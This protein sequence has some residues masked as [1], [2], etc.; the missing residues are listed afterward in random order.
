[1][2]PFE[3]LKGNGRPFFRRRSRTNLVQ[4]SVLLCVVD[5]AVEPVG[6]EEAGGVVVHG[7]VAHGAAEARRV[8][9]LGRHLEDVAVGDGVAAQRALRARGPGRDHLRLKG[10][11]RESNRIE[12]R[13]RAESTKTEIENQFAAAQ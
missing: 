12:F 7:R 5:L 3:D 9:R 11:G 8:P 1:M 13:S 10:R 2:T 4:I 6:P